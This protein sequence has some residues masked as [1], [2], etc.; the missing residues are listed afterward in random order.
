MNYKT[1]HIE[2]ESQ[3]PPFDD[4]YEYS[5]YFHYDHLKYIQPFFEIEFLKGYYEL[6]PDNYIKYF[7]NTT[8]EKRKHFV[9]W[10]YMVVL[11]TNFLN[12]ANLN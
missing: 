5:L 6:W 7:F 11:K 10:L 9:E 4:Q 3:Q 1:Y 8:E 2:F 12:P